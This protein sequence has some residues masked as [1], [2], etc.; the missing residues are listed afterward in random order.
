ME[1]PVIDPVGTGEN[2]RQLIR[3]SGDTVAAV[4]RELGI[5][6][7]STM[8]KWLRGDAL[9]TLDNMMALSVLFNVTINDILVT[10]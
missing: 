2:I 5:A 1:Y 10:R 4:G 9:P 3:N 8:Y 7:R 6:D